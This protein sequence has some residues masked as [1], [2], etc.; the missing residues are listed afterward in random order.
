[1]FEAQWGSRQFMRFF[2]LSTIGAGLLAIPLS[3]LVNLVMPFVDVTV[4]MGPDAAIDAMMVALALLFPNSTVLFGF[5]LPVKARTLIYILLGIQVVSGIQ[6]G[7]ASLSVTLG[8][9]LMGYL[10]VT[11]NW[12]PMRWWKRLRPKPKSRLYVV[13]PKQDQTLH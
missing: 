12:R 13:L 2:F 11:G 3:A 9:M 8:G 7:A 4:A 6:S 10:L 1:M 5:L